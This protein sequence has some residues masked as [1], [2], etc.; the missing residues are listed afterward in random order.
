LPASPTADKGP[1]V[2]A[3]AGASRLNPVKCLSSYCPARRFP[4]SRAAVSDKMRHTSS[5]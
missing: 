2:L 4:A 1:L 5:L 3:L